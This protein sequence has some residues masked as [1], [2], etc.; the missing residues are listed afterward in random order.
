DVAEAGCNTLNLIPYDWQLPTLLLHPLLK[1]LLQLLTDDFALF[2]GPSLELPL[3]L[4]LLFHER[5][6]CRLKIP[7]QVFDF[8]RRRRFTRHCGPLRARRK[9][10]T[11]RRRR[12]S[13]DSRTFNN[14]RLGGSRRRGALRRG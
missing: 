14:G 11:I 3:Q 2:I 1:I 8:L 4:L 13:N 9:I 12:G 6:P 5:L 7:G 10:W